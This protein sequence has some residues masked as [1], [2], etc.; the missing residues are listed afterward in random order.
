[1]GDS[2]TCSCPHVLLNHPGRGSVVPAYTERGSGEEWEVRRLIIVVQVS[3]GEAKKR[4]RE[5][6]RESKRERENGHRTV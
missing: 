4:E 3:C 2:L 5:R 6:E 1:M